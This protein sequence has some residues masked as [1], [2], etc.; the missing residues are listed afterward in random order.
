MRMVAAVIVVLSFCAV[1]VSQTSH[2]TKPKVIQGSGCVEKA[3]EHS[4]HFVI[5]SK[6]GNTY[7]LL[8]NAKVPKPGTAIWFKGAGHEG[9]SSC[10][11]GTPLTVSKWKKE[12]GIKC[13]PPVIASTTH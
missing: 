5:D 4:C 9:A 7:N 11:Q 13:P 12:K 3:V 8:F 2:T 10:M 6:T 1:G